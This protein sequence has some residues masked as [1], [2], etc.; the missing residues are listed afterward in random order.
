M[1]RATVVLTMLVIW[2]G[3]ISPVQTSAWQGTSAAAQQPPSQPPAPAV[4]A[5]APPPPPPD[6]RPRRI[7]SMVGYIDDAIIESQ[8][9]V[10]FE[11]GW[12]NRVPDRA[13]FFYAK[14]G[15]Y[16]DLD[17][18]PT[19]PAV[20]PFFDP[21]APGPGP[22]VLTELDFRQVMV[23]A[24]YAVN[25]RFA[26]FGEVPLRWIQPQAFAD[27][28]NGDPP[29]GF[30]NQG[31]F[32][33]LRAGA[34][35]GL[36]AAPDYA[37][38]FRFQAYFPTGTASKGLGTDHASVEPA[39]LYFQKFPN[40]S[41]RL[42]LESQFGF[43]LPT[44]GSEGPRPGIDDNFSGNVLFYGIGPSY[45]VY[46]SDTLRIAPVVELVGWRVLSGFETPPGTPET[47]S[48]GTN[49]VNL[50]FGARFNFRD[51]NSLY[52][53]YGTSLTDESW[54]DDILRVEY[55]YGF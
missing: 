27:R 9:R 32:G 48:S 45:V 16:R 47:D 3:V 24:E 17:K 51:R 25:G 41:D 5:P 14:C 22:D 13:E 15:C 42:A 37:I 10:R 29:V 30:G 2:A 35:F 33:D 52:V 49:I 21:N 40:T 1:T 53:G 44:G 6:T 20:L 38:T 8:V 12:S 28:P 18:F 55:R 7:G 36:A 43:W 54:Y 19:V 34:K 31:G 39:I 23:E 50:K 11:I 26:V 46:E 4:P